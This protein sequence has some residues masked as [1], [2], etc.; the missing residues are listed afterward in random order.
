[1]SNKG[2]TAEDQFQGTI[3]KFHPP[4]APKNEAVACLRSP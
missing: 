3:S 1:M 2:E 4:P